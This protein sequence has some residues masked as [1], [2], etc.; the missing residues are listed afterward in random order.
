MPEYD[1]RPRKHKQRHGVAEAPGQAVLDDVGNLAAA[2]GNA[3]DRRNVIGLQRIL[4][5]ED[6]AQSQNC[7]HRS[8]FLPQPA[9]PTAKIAYHATGVWNFNI[10]SRPAQPPLFASRL[11]EKRFGWGAISHFVLSGDAT[12]ITAALNENAKGDDDRRHLRQ[13]VDANTVERDAGGDLNGR[14]FCLRA[15]H[16]QPRRYF[17]L[18]SRSTP[19]SASDTPRHHW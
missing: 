8:R 3:R 2:G 5:A 16:R 6:E 17:V 19:A 14:L 13:L 15:P 7:K 1:R 11:C 9:Q 10:R 18:A 4:H 12:T